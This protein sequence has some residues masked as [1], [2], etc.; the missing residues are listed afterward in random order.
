MVLADSISAGQY[1][2]CTLANIPNSATSSSSVSDEAPQSSSIMIMDGLDPL[3]AATL[4][5]NSLTF[6]VVSFETF[7][8]GDYQLPSPL[9]VSIETLNSGVT[10][11]CLNTP[12]T[13]AMPAFFGA[14]HDSLLPIAGNINEI[15]QQTS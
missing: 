10:E 6:N 14:L 8:S 3:T 4:A 15:L 12:V 2:Y 13:T 7:K 9:S 1:D 5:E 11:D